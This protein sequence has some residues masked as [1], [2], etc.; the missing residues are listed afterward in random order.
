MT[1]NISEMSVRECS[2]ALTRYP[3]A[4]VKDP[5]PGIYDTGIVSD[6][7]AARLYP[8]MINQYNIG[9][10]T[11]F[12][13]L[14]PSM[15][16]NNFKFFEK[17]FGKYKEPPEGSYIAFLEYSER[18]VENLK[19]S[20]DDDE[21]ENKFKNKNDAKQYY[22]YIISY[23]FKKILQ[24]GFTLEELCNPKTLDQY[25]VSRTYFNNLIEA[26]ETINPCDREYNDLAYKYIVNQ[27]ELRGPIRIIEH[28]NDPTY[29][30][31][32]I[33]GK[34]FPKYLEENK[35]GLTI[36]GTL[37]KTHENE[38]SIFYNF[39]NE[40]YS[41][42]NAYKKQMYTYPK[43]SAGFNEFNRRQ[44]TT[45]VIMNSTYGLLGMST[46]RYSNKW[47]AKSITTS[48]RLALKTAQFYAEKYLETLE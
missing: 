34:D 29:R 21:T 45:K 4:Y 14:I 36:S 27:E 28:Y 13:R 32:T 33:D 7:D 18:F 3:G 9:L 25:I 20:E 48:G 6:L 5:I 1:W 35:L 38:L 12:G 2:K 44:S 23:L 42:R 17:Y 43:G 39:L 11:F 19:D 31:I 41:L 40:L 16:K 24:S 26:M 10:N 8:S 46:F 15:S 47:L 30:I 37:F 22:Y